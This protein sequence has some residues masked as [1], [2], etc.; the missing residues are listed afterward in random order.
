M[1]DALFDFAGLNGR[2]LHAA[3]R[4][5]DADQQHARLQEQ[6]ISTTQASVVSRAPP[7]RMQKHRASYD[8][9]R[10]K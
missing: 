10:I 4:Q 1:T 5:F 9:V 6:G 3:W 8:G 7:P 2:E